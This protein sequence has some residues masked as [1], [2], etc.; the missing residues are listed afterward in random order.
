MTKEP[1]KAIHIVP[2]DSETRFFLY[3]DYLTISNTP[4]KAQRKIYF[5]GEQGF[6]K[7]YV[8]P[9]EESAYVAV[10]GEKLYYLSLEHDRCIKTE[11]FKEL[12]AIAYEI[13]AKKAASFAELYESIQ[14]QEKRASR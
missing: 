7:L 1:V 2:T 13:S 9:D 10:V 3:D 8:S 11:E 6:Y 5:P 4:Y 12:A 14:Q